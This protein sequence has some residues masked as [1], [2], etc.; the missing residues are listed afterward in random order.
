MLH[1]NSVSSVNR[2]SAVLPPSPMVCFFKSLHFGGLI[3]LID[4]RKKTV[5][6]LLE[7]GTYGNTCNTHGV[8]AAIIDAH[9]K[10]QL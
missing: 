10:T 4:L 7:F 2:Y 5:N 6:E 1:A 8:S 3:D 9:I